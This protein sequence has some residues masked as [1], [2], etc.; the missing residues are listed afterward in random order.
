MVLLRKM[1]LIVS[2]AE[3]YF[4]KMSVIPVDVTIVKKCVWGKAMRGRR[5]ITGHGES[6]T[7]D[8][9]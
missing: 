3:R 8:R 6:I 7:E 1:K 5:I 9:V 4:Y 2:T